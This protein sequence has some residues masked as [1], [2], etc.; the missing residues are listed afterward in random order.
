MGWA[1]GP[2]GRS[3]QWTGPSSARSTAAWP[4][5]PRSIGRKAGDGASTAA[6]RKTRRYMEARRVTRRR[7]QRQ[8]AVPRCLHGRC[9][10]GCGRQLQD[11]HVLHVG[12]LAAPLPER[13]LG[14]RWPQPAQALPV[15]DLPARQETWQRSSWD[16]RRT[17]PSRHH[18][19]HSHHSHHSDDRETVLTRASAG[20][21]AVF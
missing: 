14:Q 6:P 20:S 19:H 9:L 3:W 1:T 5:P 13:L 8:R 10:H 11:P 12:T 21:V 4:P 16:R 18:C 17:V 2:T 15:R 7:Q